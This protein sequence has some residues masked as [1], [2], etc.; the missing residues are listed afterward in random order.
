MEST[1]SRM[2]KRRVAKIMGETRCLYKIEINLG[3]ISEGMGEKGTNGPSYLPD[4]DAMR[5][6]G[7]VKIVLA[8]AE[9]LRLRLKTTERATMDN[10]I[11]INCECATIV[12]RSP[13]LWKAILVTCL[14]SR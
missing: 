5:Q 8:G 10:A 4:L 9:N 6:T 14:V 2:A 13:R 3:H 12:V 11:S 7:P 1:F